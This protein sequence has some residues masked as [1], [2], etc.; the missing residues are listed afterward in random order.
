MYYDDTY[1]VE[2]MDIGDFY[3]DAGDYEKAIKWY[4]RALDEGYDEAKEK[5]EELKKKIN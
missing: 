5:L 1:Y 2:L 4:T 3:S